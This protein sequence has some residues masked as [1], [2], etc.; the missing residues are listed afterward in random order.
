[1]IYIFKT[2]VKTKNEVRRLKPH[3]NSILRGERWN[4]DLQDCDKILRVE[5]E[6]DI[7]PK[8][9]DLLTIQKHFCEELEE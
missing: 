8:I 3:I 6:K 9:K 1:M 2:S 5:S 7:A 4:F